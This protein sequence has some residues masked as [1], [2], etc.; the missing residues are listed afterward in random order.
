MNNRSG[1]VEYSRYMR[2][3]GEQEAPISARIFNYYNV[4]IMLSELDDLQY[5]SL[6]EAMITDMKLEEIFTK[7][8]YNLWREEFLSLVSWD[9]NSF[10][11]N[12]SNVYSLGG[13]AETT[14]GISLDPV[15]RLTVSN[16]DLGSKEK[17]TIIK[18][19]YKPKII[20]QGID[21][22]SLDSFSKYCQSLDKM[23]KS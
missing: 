4:D 1:N 17:P 7:A 11:I 15:I 19:R 8:L 20:V 21:I 6:Q 10:V 13:I 2:A 9:V 22:V 3:I 18:E 5:M 12:E 23:E 14:K 16:I